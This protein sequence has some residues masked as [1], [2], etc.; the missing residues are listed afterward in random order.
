MSHTPSTPPP[1]NDPWL[2]AIEP[3]AATLGLPAPLDD[4]TRHLLEQALT[5]SS[6]T[7][8]LKQSNNPLPEDWLNNY[9]RLEF[10]G[11][12]VLKLVVSE[13]LFEH[14]P[15]Y[16]EGE[17]TKIRAVVVSD[18]M[19]AEFAE[20]IK[21]GHI[22]RFGPNEAKQ[23]GRKKQSSL[24]CSFE[25]LLGALFLSGHF[26][27]ARD[28]LLRFLGDACAR[29]DA[30]PTRNNYKA[31]LQEFTQGEGL[32]LPDYRVAKQTGPAHKRQFNI[33]VYVADKCVG[34]GTGHS[35]KEAQ[36][37]AAQVAVN[38]LDIHP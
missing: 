38:A 20:D 14:F 24:A 26:I 17:L 6:Y 23:G 36:Q 15:H 19:L 32:G 2:E 1:S 34:T 10:L 13:Y 33:E 29:V 7:Y 18:A 27:L 12:A 22:M 9:E 28:L 8:E 31:V 5:H 16:R 21:L 3:F 37:A 4:H 35:K 25:A 30:D 11:D